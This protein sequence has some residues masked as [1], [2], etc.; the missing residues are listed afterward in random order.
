MLLVTKKTEKQHSRKKKS[1][2]PSHDTTPTTTHTT[3]FDVVR[4]A[5]ALAHLHARIAP[6]FARPE[7]RHR[8]LTYLQGLLSAIERKNGW[9]LAEYAREA[10]SDGMQRLL[11]RLRV[12]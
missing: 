9:Q 2:K 11:A 7:T 8:A 10:R 3:I 4:W 12:G 6:R 1:M 5:E